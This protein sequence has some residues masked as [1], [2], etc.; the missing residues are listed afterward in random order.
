M[1]DVVVI[2]AGHN[3]LVAS[4]LLARAGL[5]VEVLERAAVVGGAC[6]TERPFRRA[7]RLCASTGAYLLGLMPPE[8]LAA[9]DLDLPLVRRDPH[10]FLP[11]LDGRYLLLGADTAAA[12]DRFIRFFTERDWRANEEL[13]TELAALRD[14][15]APSWLAEPCTVEETAER[16]V[17]P[18]L[19]ET[20]VQL[21][22]GSVI[23]YLSRFGFASELLVAMYAVTD[24]MPGL[25]GSPW[26]AGSGHNLLVHNMCRL[27]GA[28][29]TWMV[30][31]GGMG[32]V[33][34]AIAA[35]AVAAG[36]AI[37]TGV[38]AERILV[39]RGIATGVVNQSGEEVRARTV[40]VATDPFRLVA[41]LGDA[42]PDE[43][44][45]RIRGYVDRS[46]GQTMKVNLALSGLP[47]FALLPEPRGQ[48]STTVHLLPE[49]TSDGSVLTAL[50]TAFDAADEGRLDPL[51]PIE[52][53]LHSLLDPSLQD[54]EGRHSSAFFVQ[55][56]A[57]TP[58]GSTWEAEKDRYVE[59]LLA[60]AERYAPGLQALV[61]DVHALPP[62]EIETH[63]GITHGNIH[64]IDNAI[65][66]AERMP[67]RVGVVGVYAGAAGCH[68]AGS[69]IGCAGYNAASAILADLGLKAR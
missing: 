67:Y 8:L 11:S 66:F 4:A 19:R 36:A 32:T 33:T 15:L 25:S 40:L 46:L 60:F 28:G 14:D 41:L 6:R 42:C 29:G 9:L 50:R 39:D 47:R 26:R 5:S 43:L 12:R 24:G 30:V 62:P 34:Q 31:R 56:V 51:P 45:S 48:H 49:P 21:V 55:G 59:R 20:F 44:R 64:H 18:Q 22:R 17:R 63:F 58:A 27:P 23:D 3:G 68:P 57:H 35:R 69:V 61:A 54:E 16:H 7:P 1:R 2:G 13:G 37:R 52:W 53:Y 65:A 38:A 10:Y